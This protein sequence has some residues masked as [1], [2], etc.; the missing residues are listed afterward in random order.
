MICHTARVDDEDALRRRQV[1][2][3]RRQRAMRRAQDFGLVLLAIGV[4]LLCVAA[5]F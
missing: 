3:A 2:W 5:L 1:D 4:L